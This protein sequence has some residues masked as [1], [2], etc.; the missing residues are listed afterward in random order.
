MVDRDLAPALDAELMGFAFLTLGGWLGGMVEFVQGVR[1]LH[2]VEEPALRAAPPL[3]NP[4]KQ[5]AAGERPRPSE[6]ER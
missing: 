4:E 5:E 2:L 3:A 1:V 6:G